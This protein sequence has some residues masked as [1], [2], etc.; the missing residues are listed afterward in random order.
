MSTVSNNSTKL[1]TKLKFVKSNLT[2]AV[3]SFVSQ[4]PKTGQFRGVR[5]DEPYPKKICLLDKKLVPDVLLNVLY[6]ATLIPMAEKDGYVVIDIQ[7]VEFKAVIT[8]TYVPKAFYYIEVKFGHKT[9]KFDPKDGKKDSVKNLESCVRLL[10]T[11]V[12]IKDIFQVVKDFR[13]EANKLIRQYEQD[14]FIYQW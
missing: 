2:G 3:V 14:G 12:D 7:P 13:H 11:R 10:E 4:N 5:K 8:T 1:S 6:E 9:I